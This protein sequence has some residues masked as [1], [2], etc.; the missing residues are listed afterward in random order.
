MKKGY[1]VWQL[2]WGSR[3]TSHLSATQI[4]DAKAQALAGQ[5]V[6]VHVAARDFASASYLEI[7]ALLMAAVPQAV[8]Q[9]DPSSMRTQSAACVHL[10]L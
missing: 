8:Q 10:W 5:G 6:C 4:A 3:Q 7:S 1:W 2:P 9:L